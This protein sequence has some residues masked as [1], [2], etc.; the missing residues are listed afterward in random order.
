[1]QL[2]P[3]DIS[4]GGGTYP[5]MFDAHPPFQI[6]GNFG[7]SAGIAEMLM[8]SDGD[9][10]LLLPALPEKWKSGEIRG[11]RA[12]GGA[13]VDITWKDGRITDYKINGG[14]PCEIIKCR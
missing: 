4:R 10:I 2:T 1:M 5:N 11:L 3:A 12:K 8:Q 14:K 7:A 9:R 13:K 6:D